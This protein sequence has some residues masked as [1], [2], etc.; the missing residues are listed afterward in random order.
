[1]RAMQYPDYGIEPRLVDLPVPEPA[2]TEV[3]VRVSYTSV[4]PVDWK[5][6]SGKIRLVMPQPRPCV[7]GY[8][9]S[10]VIDAVGERVKSFTV[11]DRV[12]I[13]IPMS[14]AGANAEY[15]VVPADHAVRLPDT[16]DL[17]T[18]AALPL[19]GMTALQGLRDVLQ[20]DLDGDTRRVLVIGASGGV[21]HFAVQI[22]AAAGAEVVGV[23]SGRNVDLARSL[24]CR[25]VIDYTQPG[26]WAGVA[27]FDLVY[28]CVAG[29]PTPYLVHLKRGGAYASCMP[30]PATF[31]HAA[32]LFSGKRVRPVLLHGNAPDL[33]TLDRLYVEGK[34]QA[35]IDRHF[36]LAEL[37]AAWA[38]S[39]S[40]RAR[41]K[42]I[43]DVATG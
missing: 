26:C 38:H 2:P 42:I 20:L 27:P 28:D 25:D 41:G 22:A 5:Q 16:M 1:M 35:V 30:G 11:G 39:Q 17:V 14:S 23:C 3:R 40:G 33:D 34:L 13:R 8:D 24:G 6:A 18:A 7:P 31:L 43:I 19:A 9:L 37:P 12:H 10:G 32:N 21:G 15:A 29:D 4:N 36:G